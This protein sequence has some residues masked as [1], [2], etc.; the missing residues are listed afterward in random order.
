VIVYFEKIAG[1]RWA[2][3]LNERGDILYRRRVET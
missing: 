2:V 3:V 1:V